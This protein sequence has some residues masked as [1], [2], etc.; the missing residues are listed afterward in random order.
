MAF[1]TTTT[2]SAM[3]RSPAQPQNELMMPCTVRSITQSLSTKAWFLA[4][5][6]ACTRLPLAAAVAVDVQPD[7]GGAD[8]GHALDVRMRQQDLG[9][10]AAGGDDVQNARRAAPLR[11]TVR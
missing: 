6:S 9:L 11:T 5:V 10:V 8:K 3:Q 7:A 1:S 2:G 4:S